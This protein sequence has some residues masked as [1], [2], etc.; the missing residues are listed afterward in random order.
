M[1]RHVRCLWAAILPAVVVFHAGTLSAS[2]MPSYIRVRILHTRS[3]FTLGSTGSYEYTLLTGGR[4]R[5]SS[6]T[7]RVKPAKQKMRIGTTLFPGDVLVSP[8]QPSEHLLI[9]GRHYRGVLILEPLRSGYVDVVEQV[10]TDEYLYGVLPK[11]VGADWPME[12]LKAQAIVSRTYVLANKAS[13]PAQRYD[14]ASDV[15]YQVYGGFDSEADSTNRAV[16][17]T[18]GEIL[19][20]QNEQPIQ[21]FFHSSCGGRTETPENVWFRVDPKPAFAS[22]ADE[23]CREDPY[24]HWQVDM[25]A[26]FIRKRLRREGMLVGEIRQI[27]LGKKT[28]SGRP[29]SLVLET[30][31]GRREIQSNRFRLAIGPEVLRSTLITE[32][33]RNKKLF[34]WEGR[35]WGHGVGL[36][37]WGARGRALAGHAYEKILR[38]YY[39][40]ARLIK[41]P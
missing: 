34:H 11:E 15:T 18:K 13:D 22:I 2:Q 24:A 41:V 21:T 23:F 9:N 10:A 6:A 3:S 7:T 12:A 35:G 28:S 38:A 8:K 33:D 37:Q 20:D 14:V 32:L 40:R 26:A 36:C 5:T 17:E 16:D 39:P 4:V 25:S 30:S 19:V 29:V 27:K 1:K 31:S